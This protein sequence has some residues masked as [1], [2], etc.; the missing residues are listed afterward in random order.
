M[1]DEIAR[2]VGA[3]FI[4]SDGKVLLGLRSP[5]KKAWP[6]HWDSIGGRVEEARAW[7]KR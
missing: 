2:T 4:N 1:P 3:L 5:T 7:R 6:S